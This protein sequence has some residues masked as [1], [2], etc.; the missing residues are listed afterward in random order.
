MWLQ[1]GLGNGDTRLSL[2]VSSMLSSCYYYLEAKG[3]AANYFCLVRVTMMALIM[4]II[5]A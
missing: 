5:L 4:R 2:I 1:M 3:K